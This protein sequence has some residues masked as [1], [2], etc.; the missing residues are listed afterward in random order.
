MKR[1]E[2]LTI[3]LT[4]LI[5]VVFILLIFFIVTSVFKKDNVALK[6]NLPNSSASSI[7][8]KQKELIIELNSDSIGYGGK[9]IDFQTLEN[10][11]IKV[12]K[13]DNPVIVK[14]DENTKYDRVVKLLDLLQKHSLNNLALLTNEK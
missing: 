2:P 11:L 7:K 10:H 13:K 5:D 3:D 6:L 9:T 1:R 8:I 14:I 12:T 4:P